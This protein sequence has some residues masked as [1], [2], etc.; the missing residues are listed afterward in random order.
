MQFRNVLL[1]FS[2]ELSCRCSAAAVDSGRLC[3]R[4]VVALL[5]LGCYGVMSPISAQMVDLVCVG[6]ISRIE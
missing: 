3:C 5:A 4:V 1:V 2:R 6:H